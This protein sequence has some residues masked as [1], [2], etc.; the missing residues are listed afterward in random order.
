MTRHLAIGDIHGCFNSLTSLLS[1]VGLRD[2]DTIV[3]LGDYIDRGPD[4]RSVLDLLI[5]LDNSHQLVPLRGNH[6]VMMLDA[7]VKTS[8]LRPWLSN[9][10]DATLRSYSA[11]EDGAVTFDDIPDAHYGFLENRLLPYYECA[12]HF[13]V[14]AG[15]DVNT[16]LKAPG[17]RGIT[18][19]QSV[20]IPGHSGKVG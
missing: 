2:D 16:H 20:L 13:F 10:G 4:S 8:W 18:I 15:V 12:T 3:T 17:C 19:I 6:E 1:F 14:H 9:G 7:R 5:K 11:G